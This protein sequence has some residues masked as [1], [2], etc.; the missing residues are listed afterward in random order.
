MYMRKIGR[1]DSIGDVYQSLTRMGLITPVFMTLHV[2]SAFPFS[3]GV[4]EDFDISAIINF[5]CVS[6]IFYKIRDR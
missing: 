1:Y 4:T 5:K 3:K 2:Q 6:M